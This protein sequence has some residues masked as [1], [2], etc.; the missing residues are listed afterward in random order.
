LNVFLSLSFVC[1]YF[2]QIYLFFS[3]CFTCKVYSCL[4]P[5]V[6]SCVLVLIVLFLLLC[7]YVCSICAKNSIRLLNLIITW[8]AGKCFKKIVKQ[9]TR[10]RNFT[11]LTDV[12]NVF[13]NNLE[14]LSIE[15]NLWFA[16]VV[17]NKN[18]WTQN[19][20]SFPNQNWINF[21]CLKLLL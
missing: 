11:F 10:W 8:L 18:D 1:L 2:Q 4:S 6:Q 3:F 17:V 16:F 5:S 15:R 19:L 7:S 20:F 9:K 13:Q 14:C 12:W 21:Q